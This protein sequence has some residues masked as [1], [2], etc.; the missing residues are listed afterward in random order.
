MSR[1]LHEINNNEYELG[2]ISVHAVQYTHGVRNREVYQVPSIEYKYSRY[3]DVSV[4]DGISGT[5]D[6]VLH[7]KK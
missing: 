5:Y 4:L 2:N 3:L 7:G 1:N 6:S